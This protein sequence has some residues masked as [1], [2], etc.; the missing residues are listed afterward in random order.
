MQST[1]LESNQLPNLE[2][3]LDRESALELARRSMLGAPVYTVVSL[4]MLAG[5]PML[6]DYGIWS[7]AEA[8]ALI[9]LG[10]V[11]VWFALHFE[12]RYEA[13]GERAIVHFNILT[14][15]QSLTLGVLSAMVIWQYW[16]TQEVILTIVLSAGCIAAGTSALSVRRS[17]HFIFL[18]CVLA[19]FGIAV[20]LVGGLAQAA[21][22]VGFLSLMAFL[23]QD[24]G[25]A[26]R[27][28]FHHLKE[29][30]GEVIER[31]RTVLEMQAKEEYI[32][33]IGHEILEPV[34]SIIGMTAL[35]LDEKLGS[36]ACEIAQTIRK[37]GNVLFSLIGNVP[38]SIRSNPDLP[39]VQA[40]AFELKQCIS[41]VFD[42]YVPKADAKGLELTA[43]LEDIPDKLI[44]CDEYQL[45][46]VLAN[47]LSNAVEF[48]EQGS[49]TLDAH[50]ETLMDG[51]VLIEFSVA[52]TGVGIPLEY[53]ESVF[54]PFNLDGAKTSGKFGGDGLGLPLS[55]GLVELMGGDIWI[56]DNEKQGTVI[57]FTIQADLD[58]SDTS[59]ISATVPNVDASDQ[60]PG[61]G[62]PLSYT[63]P[64][65]ILVV[66]D[67]A[68]H[69]HIVCVQLK[70]MG[71][72]ADEAADGEQ[73]VAAVLL[74]DY[75]LIFMDL[76]M[77]KM[78]GIESSRWIR[79]RFSGSGNVRIIALTGDATVDAR[80][81][82]MRA[83]M[84]NFVTKP[85]QVKDL[86]A[87]LSHSSREHANQRQH[88][89][90]VA[91]SLH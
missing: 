49:I 12:Q 22:I 30:Y 75:D 19:P 5:T 1:I 56:E 50:C 73:A 52:D 60:L 89:I 79:E 43:E 44:S 20:Y 14:A 17:A 3:Y 88:T 25:Q 86:V 91:G 81:Q 80:E 21:L 2:V 38:G 34:N 6:M 48:T 23:V 24:G 36:R 4:I 54:N 26:K 39:E 58:P 69:R 62:E 71:Y 31:R 72:E 37:S 66:D 16:A 84:D 27:I 46:Q 28:Y 87:I 47:L 59:W 45:E 51:S 64:H 18:A 83:G 33:D 53:R 63:Y 65:R 76:R 42:L 9:L 55:K 7:I 85:V 35:L 13:I 78:N 67:D 41:N 77:P 57:K 90:Q 68:I 32:R 82:C 15:L 61:V 11:R 40:G 74:G 70:K 8:L 29:H 10:V